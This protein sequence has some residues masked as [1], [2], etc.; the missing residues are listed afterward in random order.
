MFDKTR[1]AL[2]VWDADQG[3]LDNKLYNAHTN[4]EI[5]AWGADVKAAADLVRAAFYE[6]TK[7]I[8]TWDQAKL[9]HP[10]DP[11]L[12]KLVSGE[13]TQDQR[14]RAREWANEHDADEEK[15]LQD[16]IDIDNAA[17]AKAKEKGWG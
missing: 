1:E 11:W 5:W 12:R 8:N 3:R 13:P 2:K 4:N 14:D 16:I 9:V 7:G 17:T 10:R 6:D 15:A